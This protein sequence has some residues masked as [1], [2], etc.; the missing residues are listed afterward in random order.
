MINN[1]RVLNSNPFFDM[2]EAALRTVGYTPKKNE[3]FDEKWVMKSITARHSHIRCVILRLDFTST[4]PVRDQILRSKHGYAE[5]YVKSS[6]PDRTGESRDNKMSSWFHD[7]NI[8]G[9]IKMAG[10]RLCTQTEI[11]TRKEIESLKAYMELSGDGVIATIGKILS[12]KCC[13]YGCCNEFEPKNCFG[14]CGEYKTLH[15]RVGHYNRGTI[16]GG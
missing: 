9:L 12:P 16:T 1:V 11:H 14:V 13:W 6:R 5:P 7:F 10:D 8:E 15:G 2:R 4:K 3:I